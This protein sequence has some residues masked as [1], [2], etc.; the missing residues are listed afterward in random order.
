MYEVDAVVRRAVA[1][2]LTP[3]AERARGDQ[4]GHERQESAA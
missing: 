2:Q 3:E 1:L 4:E